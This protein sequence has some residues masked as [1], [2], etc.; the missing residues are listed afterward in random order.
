M[1]YTLRE[2]SELTQR[3]VAALVG[4]SIIIGAIFWSEW[5]YFAIFF[6]ICT[7]AMLEFYKLLGLDGNLPLKT[8]GTFNGL[9]VYTLTFLVERGTIPSKYYI[10]I[11]MGL[12]GV[13]FVKLYRK[14][15]A[16]PFVGIALTF[17]GIVYIAVPMAMLNIF[18]FF[19][20]HYHGG[21]I[22]GSL[23]ILWANDTGA[24]FSGK[25]FGKR[26]LF[27]RISPKKTWEGSLGGGVL[28]VG[29]GILFS[30]FYDSLSLYQWVIVAVIVTVTGTYGD[31]IESL[32]KRSIM[33]KDS[34]NAIPGHGGFLDRFDGL[35]IAAPVLAVYLKLFS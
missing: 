3:I 20:G 26:K 24:Y 14:K 34:G 28:A 30:H 23:F 9:L 22:L 2:R 21:I 16:K 18:V 33:I 6:F 27:E 5:S 1:K 4:V 15:D 12:S 8:F 17:L 35:F 31:L 29:M 7:F 19:D 32:F 11:F 25:N 10:L 13:Y